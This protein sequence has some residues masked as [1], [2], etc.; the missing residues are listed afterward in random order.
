[1]IF[2]IGVIVV[3]RRTTLHEIGLSE[4]LSYICCPHSLAICIDQAAIGLP[5]ENHC[6]NTVEQYRKYKTTEQQQYKCYHQ[7]LTQTVKEC[8]LV[9]CFVHSKEPPQM[10]IAVSSGV[11]SISMILI[12]MKGVTT[13]PKPRSEEH[14]SELQ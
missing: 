12:P 10:P 2:I 9:C 5:G 3:S 4:I 11:M 8:V 13:P 7:R 6:G 1:F 14:T